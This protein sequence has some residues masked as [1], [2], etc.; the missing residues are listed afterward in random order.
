MKVLRSTPNHETNLRTR[1]GPRQ[2]DLGTSAVAG[3]IVGGLFVGTFLIVWALSQSNTISP[4]GIVIHHTSV[5]PG[6]SAMEKLPL[7]RDSW[8]EF[9]RRRG[10]SVFYWGHIYHIGYH[11][12]IFPDGRVERGR[13]EH[14]VGAHAKGFNSYLGV[15]LVGDFSTKDKPAGDE[16]LAAPTTEQMHTLVVLCRH[17]RDRYNI[18][19]GRVVR[20]SD[21][22]RTECPGNRFP[23]DEFLRQLQ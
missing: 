10:F 23:Y 17:L 5:M 16:A 2:R 6:T 9:H 12:M 21:I 15:V 19:L 4:N 22:G 18:P 13:P 3:R 20:H 11:Y 14:C 7:D 8:D 1:G